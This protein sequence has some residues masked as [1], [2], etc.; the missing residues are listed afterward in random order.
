VDELSAR[1]D[2]PRGGDDIATAGGATD[3][4]QIPDGA[5]LAGADRPASANADA[6]EGGGVRAIDLYVWSKPRDVEGPEAAALVAAWQRAGGDPTASPFELTTDIG[7]FFRELKEALPS[8]DAVSDAKPRRSSTPIW[9]SGT[10]EAPARVVA[11]RLTPTASR[12]EASEIFSL[13]MKYD[14]V[15]FDPH[16][17]A[18]HRP[19]EQMSAYASST[20]WPR[21]AIRG[22]VAGIIGALLAVG[23]WVA[24]IPIVSGVVI[25][26]GV[27]L[28]VLTV[29]T[30]AHEARVRMR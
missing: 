3:G 23:A 21:G 6:H 27:F 20:F 1:R 12:D 16:R 24:G 15:V 18:V 26:V 22:A 5:I 19:L 28:V 13:A 8:L 9:M 11:V 29:A 2:N 14:L 30:F 25:V 10:D 7:W 17:D 4:A